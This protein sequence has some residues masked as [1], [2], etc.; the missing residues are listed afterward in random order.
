MSRRAIMKLR[1][2]LEHLEAKQLPS[3]GALPNHLL[4]LGAERSRAPEGQGRLLATNPGRGA[5]LDHRQSPTLPHAFLAFPITD[6]TVHKVD[7]T[8]PFGQVLVQARQPKAGQVYNVLSVVVKN[9]TSQTFT[10][11]NGFTVKFPNRSPDRPVPIL[12]GS[13]VWKPGDWIVFYVLTHK[14]YPVNSQISGGFQLNLGGRS[15]TVIPGPSGIFLRLAYKPAT[16]AR[17]LDWIVAY[18]QGAQLGKGPPF[19][20][21]DTQ[22]YQIVAARTHRIN[23]AGHF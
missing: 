13:R 3:A 2:G 1:P 23:F 6:P 21:P 20:I 10:A 12:T 17:T 19:G 15:S 14:Y 5:L 9:G 18:G 8:P 16:F 22:M 4:N 7:L 11:S